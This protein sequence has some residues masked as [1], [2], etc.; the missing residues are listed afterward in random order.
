MNSINNNLKSKDTY[1]SKN[2]KIKEIKKLTKEKDKDKDNKINRKSCR[3]NF[4]NNNNFYSKNL[5]SV[6]GMMSNNNKKSCK[7]TSN[8]NLLSNTVFEYNKSQ[9]SNN[10]N[11]F[12][13]Y[14]KAVAMNKNNKYSINKSISINK[15]NIF[16]NVS[17]KKPNHNITF[18]SN[19][20]TN[21]QTNRETN[22]NTLHCNQNKNIF[23]KSAV[24]SPKSNISKTTKSSP[25]SSLLNLNSTLNKM[26]KKLKCHIK[27]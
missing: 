12:E 8:Q 25:K 15:S 7:N 2:E 18:N 17:S 20:I 11:F 19:N 23:P 3:F 6:K 16:N 5:Y 14:V 22:Q 21:S 9:H 24:H 4:F 10:I 27:N 1:N 26:S 13:N